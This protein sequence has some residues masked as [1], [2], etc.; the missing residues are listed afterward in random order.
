MKTLMKH[1]FLSIAL[2]A[3][4]LASAPVAVFAQAAAPAATA[5]QN[6]ASQVVLSSS[7]RIL[8]TLDQ[9]RAE[10]KANPA[11]LRQY[12]TSEFNTLFDGDYSARLVLGVHGRGATNADMNLLGQ[13]QTERLM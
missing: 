9:R 10:F 8:T 3:A 7:T 11:A 2:S 13:A 6:S 1:S 4:M 5:K 12:V